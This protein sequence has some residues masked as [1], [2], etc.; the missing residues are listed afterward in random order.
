MAHAERCPICFGKGTI[1]VDD[2][3][4][5]TKVCHGCGGKG[6]VEVSDSPIYPVLPRNPEYPLV[7]W[8]THPIYC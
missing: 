5:A 1:P 4:G 3:T 2:Y 7:P 8:W 6:W